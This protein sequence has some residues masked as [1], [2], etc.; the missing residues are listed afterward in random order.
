MRDIQNRSLC[1][2]V[3]KNPR[4]AKDCPSPDPVRISS[5]CGGGG[6]G[7]WLR[8]AR[9]VTRGVAR[10]AAVLVAGPA[11]DLAPAAATAAAVAVVLAP[12]GG[13]PLLLGVRVDVCADDEA[14]DVEKGHPRGLGQEL[15]RKGQRDGRHDPADLHDGHEARLDRG[16]DLVECAGARDERHRRQVHAV[17]DGRDLRTSAVH[18]TAPSARALTIRLLKRICRI[19]A[20]T[21]VRPWNSFCRMLMRTWPSGALTSAP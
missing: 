21:L 18:T 10:V 7:G 16:A 20:L 14:D 6:G 12:Q 4:R 8:V 2:P 3:H 13:E 11:A 17:L 1:P 19:L 9:L 5:R 15:L